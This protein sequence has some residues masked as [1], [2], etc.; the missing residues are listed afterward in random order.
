VTRR[1]E[2]L[3][4][5]FNSV[6]QHIVGSRRVATIHRR[7]AE[8]YARYLPL[9]ILEPPYPLPSITEAVQWHRLFDADAG[10]LWLRTLFRQVASESFAR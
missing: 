5:N 3:A 7:L 8:H 2:V 1:I 9:K 6:P 4:M 10:N